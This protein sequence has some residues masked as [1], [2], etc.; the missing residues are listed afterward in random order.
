MAS[1]TGNHSFWVSD[2]EHFVRLFEVTKKKCGCALLC[3]KCYCFVRKPCTVGSSRT[4]E[5]ARLKKKK[6][7]RKTPSGFSTPLGVL[8]VMKTLEG[9]RYI[10]INTYM[11]T[12]FEIW[13]DFFVLS[14]IA[15]PHYPMITKESSLI[16]TLR[17][18]NLAYVSPRWRP[19][20]S[21]KVGIRENSLFHS[22]QNVL[23]RATEDW[24]LRT[25]KESQSNCSHNLNEEFDSI[26]CC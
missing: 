7:E 12:V 20:H 21:V 23:L 13:G 14:Y 17:S 16:P 4:I 9:G 24:G 5:L 8:L 22:T 1:Q 11:F 25:E 6:E 19:K 3:V 18:G 15:C 26:T 2:Y 10:V